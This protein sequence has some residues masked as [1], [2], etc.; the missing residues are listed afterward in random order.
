[1]LASFWAA[2]EELAAL[3]FTEIFKLFASSLRDVYSGLMV[4]S[5][6]WGGG[7]LVRLSLPRTKFCTPAIVNCVDDS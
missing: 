6:C 5:C 3:F 2:A 1:V 7:V 4:G